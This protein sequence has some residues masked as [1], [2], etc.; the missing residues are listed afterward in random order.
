MITWGKMLNVGEE[1]GRRVGI[2]GKDGT[3][4]CYL[5]LITT[6]IECARDSVIGKGL[7]DKWTGTEALG[8]GTIGDLS[9]DSVEYS[10]LSVESLGAGGIIG[11]PV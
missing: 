1:C 7:G 5:Q 11:F 2:V 8:T 9:P 3:D 6:V 10:L 4:T